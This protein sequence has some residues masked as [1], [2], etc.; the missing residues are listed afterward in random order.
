[1]GAW[2]PNTE[3]VVPCLHREMKMRSDKK[4]SASRWPSSTVSEPG[5]CSLYLMAEYAV[6]DRHG[7]VFMLPGDKVL[8]DRKIRKMQ[9]ASPQ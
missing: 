1:M 2:S 5:V 3:E 7:G 6:F 9:A 4:L 8:Q